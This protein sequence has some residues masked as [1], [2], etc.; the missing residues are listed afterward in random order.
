MDIETAETKKVAVVC[1]FVLKKTK[2]TVAA[3]VLL[4]G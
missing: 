2:K 1:G 3:T 4:R